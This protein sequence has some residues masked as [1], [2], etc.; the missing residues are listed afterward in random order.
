ML[1]VKQKLK[2]ENGG[3]GPFGS[4]GVM[5]GAANTG[6]LPVLTEFEFSWNHCIEM[7]PLPIPGSPGIPAANVA[8]KIKEFPVEVPAASE[9]ERVGPDPPGSSGFLQ[10]YADVGTTVGESPK[11]DMLMVPN[12]DVTTGRAF[13]VTVEL[14]VMLPELESN[15]F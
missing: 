15:V 3:F 10:I 6:I 12:V 5:I 9:I 8:S 14:R 2:F 11:Y 4:V 1:P 13:V 7:F